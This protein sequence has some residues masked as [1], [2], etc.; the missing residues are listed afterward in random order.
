MAGQDYTRRWPAFQLAAYYY[1]Q[2][3]EELQVRRCTESLACRHNS[4]STKYYGRKGNNYLACEKQTP[5]YFI[6][7]AI[8]YSRINFITVLIT[9]YIR[10]NYK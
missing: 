5:S 6:N 2:M 10:R 4:G 7:H 8:N 3:P 9:Y 1:H